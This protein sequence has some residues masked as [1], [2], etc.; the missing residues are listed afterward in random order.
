M[1]K[2]APKQ[3]QEN[4]HTVKRIVKHTKKVNLNQRYLKKEELGKG[5]FGVV[6]SAFDQETSKTVAIKC[7]IDNTAIEDFQAELSLLKRLKHPSIVPYLDSFLDSKKAL[8]IVMEYAENGSLLDVI[9]TY[10]PLNE[11]ITTIYL[12]QV[13]EGLEYLH[14]QSII[15][16]D[17][18]A[19]NILMQGDGA[20]L[21]D[22][23]LAVD[24]DK[25][26]H[27]LREAAGSPYWMAPEVIRGE[28]QSY[29]AD[30]WS[31]G[32]T[33]V[34]LIEGAPPYCE[35]DSMKAM[36]K[37][38]TDGFP[39]FRIPKIMTKEF[40]DFVSKCV[41]K[42]PNNRWNA[43]QLMKHPWIQQ[44]DSL[45]RAEVMK[46][47]TETEIDL[48]KLLQMVGENTQ[49]TLVSTARTTLRN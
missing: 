42:D 37:I 3:E 41:A 13:L 36:Q 2:K 27:T 9:K 11:M 23:G 19:A 34:E 1:R 49:N 24:L 15:H 16:R 7:L 47:L 31:V 44:V 40:K 6:Y 14:H 45:D 43:V 28:A 25:Y 17:I 35:F 22:F 32:A 8:H 26:G 38:S 12:S 30:I 5:A 10:G 20:K 46:S 33:C 29:P 4:K 39:G 21:A 48:H 18:K